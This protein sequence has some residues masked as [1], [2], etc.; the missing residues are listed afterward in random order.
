[1]HISTGCVPGPATCGCGHLFASDGCLRTNN[2]SHRDPISYL[3]L[4]LLFSDPSPALT[5]LSALL[6]PHSRVVL[7]FFLNLFQT[8]YSIATFYVY[9]VS[10]SRSL[11]LAL[12]HS[13]RSVHSVYLEQVSRLKSCL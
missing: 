1:M 8:L 6:I 5:A 9:S 4:Y 12:V 11:Y 2:L 7:A 13:C 10:F 3:L